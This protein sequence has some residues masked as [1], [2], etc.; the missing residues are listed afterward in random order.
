MDVSW[1]DISGAGRALHLLTILAT[2]PSS[3]GVKR[4]SS[5]I[6]DIQAYCIRSDNDF[7]MQTASVK[8]SIAR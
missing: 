6:H 2:R 7:G 4:S 5:E 8:N 1:D 3:Q